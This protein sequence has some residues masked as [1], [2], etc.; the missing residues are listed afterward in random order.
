METLPKIVINDIVNELKQKVA[1]KKKFLSK[2]LQCHKFGN[3]MS[4]NEYVID[5]LMKTE[6]DQSHSNDHKIYTYYIGGGYSWNSLDH[7]FITSGNT[8]QENFAISNIVGILEVVYMFNNLSELKKK[9]E[10]LY[11]TLFIP[12]QKIL[13][14]NNL[15][16]KIEFENIVID[17]NQNFKYDYNYTLFKPLQFKLK[18]VIEDTGMDTSGGSKKKKK[19]PTKHT[20]RKLKT[21]LRKSVRT[22]KKRKQ[23]GGVVV[24][25]YE[26]IRNILASIIDDNRCPVK[27]PEEIKKTYNTFSIL[28]F[29]FE[30][31]FK[32]DTK[33][34]EKEI[35]ILNFHKDLIDSNSHPNKLNLYGVLLYSYLY[36]YDK[37]NDMGLNINYYRQKLFLDKHKETPGQIKETFEKILTFYENNFKNRLFD[38]YFVDKIENIINKYS[39]Y[40]YEAYIDFF[41]RL[42]VSYFRPAVNAFIVE[43][44]KE[45]NT[46]FGIKLFI[47]GGDAMRRYDPDISF[48]KDIDTKLYIK[49]VIEDKGVQ[50]RLYKSLPKEVIRASESLATHKLDIDSDV[51]VMENQRKGVVK[52][53]IIDIIVKHIVKL[54]NFLETNLPNVLKNYTFSKY[55]SDTEYDYYICF[56]VVPFIKKENQRFRTREIRKSKEFPVDLYSIDFKTYIIKLEKGVEIKTVLE[57]DDEIETIKDNIKNIKNEIKKK[58]KELKISIQED[59]TVIEN[60]I[61]SL[62]ASLNEN[63]TNLKK[64]EDEIKT[65]IKE[66]DISVLDVVLEDDGNYFANYHT[67][68]IVP[69]ASPYFIIKDFNTTY[70]NEDRTLAR[71]ASNKYVKDIERYKKMYEKYE[72]QPNLQHNELFDITIN[73]DIYKE[74]ITDTEFVIKVQSIVNKIKNQQQFILE[75]FIRIIDIVNHN[76]FNNLNDNIQTIFRKIANLQTNIL[77]E[78]LNKIQDKYKIIANEY[79]LTK[80]T[81]DREYHKLFSYMVSLKDGKQKHK[82]SFSNQM[83]QSDL[84]QAGILLSPVERSIR[85]V[86]RHSTSSPM[87]L[88]TEIGKVT[89]STG[90]RRPISAHNIRQ[91][92]VQSTATT[93][94]RP[95]SANPSIRTSGITD[96]PRNLKRQNASNNLLK[97]LFVIPENPDGG[98]RNKLRGGSKR[99]S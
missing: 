15:P 54:R 20:K 4:I 52:K 60:E 26:L 36:T 53:K 39:S 91:E 87:H 49:N 71:M 5:S 80:H 81:F 77:F 84:K 9:I 90:R 59:K 98:R 86:A 68:D 95:T 85:P 14:D 47:A 82:I 21:K 17:M 18:L 32:N 76:N 6:P 48:T 74:N 2:F 62:I 7:M 73:Y 61:K 69:V 24:G 58:N 51:I 35:F 12:L 8:N 50:N 46:T 25:K 96:I 41:S 83:I 19:I 22:Y 63:K 92:D 88:D 72:Q 29:K 97:N 27:T 37:K 42:F 79:T 70:D 40:H 43:I 57:K 11:T 99:V 56:S 33:N 55:A 75:D 23:K 78:D 13:N 93:G 31:Y 64:I 44:N 10:Y 94:K 66:L 16:T 45:L 3:N 38:K 67:D 89:N 34:D 28:E 30:Y 1:D 65:K